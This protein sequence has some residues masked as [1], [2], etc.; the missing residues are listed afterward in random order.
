MEKKVDT[1]FSL[2]IVYMG[3]ISK[4]EYNKLAYSPLTCFLEGAA[5]S[6]INNKQQLLKSTC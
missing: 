6:V 5:C 4:G 1:G 2:N 3:T